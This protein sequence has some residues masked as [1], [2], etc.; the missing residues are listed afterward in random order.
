MR[1]RTTKKSKGGMR[2]PEARPP[3]SYATYA[4]RSEQINGVAPL[5]GIVVVILLR[6]PLVLRPRP[7]WGAEV[8]LMPDDLKKKH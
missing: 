5:A 8:A 3:T 1:A 2:A 7:A 4:P 6:P